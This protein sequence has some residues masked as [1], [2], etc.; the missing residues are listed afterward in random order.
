[1]LYTLIYIYECKGTNY[2]R[3]IAIKDA[4]LLVL[5]EK[6]ISFFV[7][8]SFFRNFA[9]TWRTYMALGR[10]NK[11]VCFVLLS[12][13]RNFARKSQDFFG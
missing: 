2:F 9:T 1:M 8:P 10:K 12:F 13:F 4:K 7:L 11:R 6:R 5:G 3:N